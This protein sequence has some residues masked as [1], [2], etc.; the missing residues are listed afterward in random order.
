MSDILIITAAMFF[1]A[2]GSL[3]LL[4][5]QRLGKPLGI[6]LT[7][8]DARTEVRAVYGGYGVVMA[9]LL[10][11]AALTDSATGDGIT[12]TAACALTAMAVTRLLSYPVDRP[13]GI[14]PTWAAVG[15]ELVIAA[16]L[17]ITL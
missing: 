11:Y 3:G 10:T 4:S 5:P 7:S 17:A 8:G 15:A 2:M 9:A 13:Q 16:A 6:V 12:L 1:L 14:F